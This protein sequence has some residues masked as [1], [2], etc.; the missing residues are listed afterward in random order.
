MNYPST[1][2]SKLLFIMENYNHILN[3][4]IAYI[5]LNGWMIDE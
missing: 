4:F 1:V 5:A 2:I 3:L